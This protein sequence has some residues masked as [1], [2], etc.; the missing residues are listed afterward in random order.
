MYIHITYIHSIQTWSMMKIVSLPFQCKSTHPRREPMFPL[1]QVKHLLQ[2]DAEI[3][4]D[5]FL[6]SCLSGTTWIQWGINHV[7][8]HFCLQNLPETNNNYCTLFT[9][10][11]IY[12]KEKLSVL[13][14][15]SIVFHGDCKNTHTHKKN[16]ELAGQVCS[17]THAEVALLWF[18]HEKWPRWSDKTMR[19]YVCIMMW[20]LWPN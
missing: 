8:Y 12:L 3:I 18:S 4:K 5:G 9:G 2:A 7:T 6:S 19:P 14:V 16:L 11:Y 17:E 13:S 20:Q 1:F 10:R 15:C